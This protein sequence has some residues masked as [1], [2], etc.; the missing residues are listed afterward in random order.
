MSLADRLVLSR[1]PVAREVCDCVNGLSRVRVENVATIVGAVAIWGLPAVV[2]FQELLDSL[3][4][5]A[6]AWRP[7]AVLLGKS[8]CLPDQHQQEGHT[9][10][11]D[12][13]RHSFLPNVP[14]AT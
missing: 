10:L 2:L 11:T 8:D 7:M 9:S 14:L 12:D 5:S 3:A 13:R 1:A 6:V 4:S